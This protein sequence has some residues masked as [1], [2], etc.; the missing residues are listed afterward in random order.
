MKDTY[1]KD[2]TKKRTVYIEDLKQKYILKADYNHQRESV[3]YKINN[4]Y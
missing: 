2:L 4:L 1:E 3:L